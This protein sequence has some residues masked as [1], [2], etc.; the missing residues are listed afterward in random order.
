MKI[1]LSNENLSQPEIRDYLKSMY[2]EYLRQ[3]FLNDLQ[4]MEGDVNQYEIITKKRQEK[5][6]EFLK[7]LGEIQG[8]IT[9][10]QLTIEQ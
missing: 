6:D 9:Q 10:I 3:I 4:K 7:A 1:N 5:R 8:D 2:D